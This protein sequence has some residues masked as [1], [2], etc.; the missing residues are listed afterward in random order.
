M[1][2][3]E[4]IATSSKSDAANQATE[5]SLTPMDTFQMVKATVDPLI[6][7]FVRRIDAAEQ[8]MADLQRGEQSSK[9]LK[10]RQE[11]ERVMQWDRVQSDIQQKRNA[12]TERMAYVTVGLVVLL[13]FSIFFSIASGYLDAKAAGTAVGVAVGAAGSMVVNAAF[14]NA[15]SQKEQPAAQPPA[16]SP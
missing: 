2:V 3:P 10:L 9:E 16:T 13:I 1:Q 14:R 15:K 5:G 12:R 4:A 6:D 8:R 11:H 7:A